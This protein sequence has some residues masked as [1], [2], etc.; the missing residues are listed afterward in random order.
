MI[1]LR[2]VVSRDACRLLGRVLDEPTLPRDIS[3]LIEQINTK[4]EVVGGRVT[5]IIKNGPS[6][7]QNTGVP[8][9]TGQGEKWSTIKPVRHSFGPEDGGVSMLF[10][11][12]SEALAPINACTFADERSSIVRPNTG[13]V[14]L[15]AGVGCSF[16]DSFIHPHMPPTSH[17][18]IISWNFT[19]PNP[20]NDET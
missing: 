9:L 16:G 13:D 19:N 11:V 18:I 1:H 15:Y 3:D 5:R 7:Y 4:L 2:A 10:F 20:Q 6:R 17:Q 12:R 8:D 14:L